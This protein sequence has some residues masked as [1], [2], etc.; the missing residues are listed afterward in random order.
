MNVT[1]NFCFKDITSDFDLNFVKI[2]NDYIHFDED[3]LAPCCNECFRKPQ[4]TLKGW[5]D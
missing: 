4:R 1:C 5:I 2:E 3:N